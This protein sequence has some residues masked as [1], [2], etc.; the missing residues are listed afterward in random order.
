M[1]KV[2]GGSRRGGPQPGSGRPTKL[3]PDVADRLVLMVRAGNYLETAAAACGLSVSTVRDWI[4][5]GQRAGSGPLFDLARRIEVAQ[6]E[7]EALDVN[8]LLQHGQKDWRALAWRLE[9]R[10]PERWREVAESMHTGRDGGPIE[11]KSD[12]TRYTLAVPKN[13]ILDDPDK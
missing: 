9:R 8:K 7:S 10:F 11:I 4:R 13:G 5:K 6:G 12:V 2:S 1:S 3:D